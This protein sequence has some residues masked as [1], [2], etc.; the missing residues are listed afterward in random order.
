MKS[1]KKGIISLLAFVMALTLTPSVFAATDEDASGS[2]TAASYKVTNPGAS[3]EDGLYSNKTLSLNDDGTGTITLETY[4]TG[5]IQQTGTPTDIVLVLDVSQ[6][7]SQS[8]GSTTRLAA[9]KAAVSTFI[10]TTAKKNEAAKTE[11]LKSRISIVSFSG[12]ATVVSDFSTDATTLKSKV[13]SLTTSRG[14][15]ADYGMQ[16]AQSQVSSI[17]ASRESNKVVIFFTDGEPNHGSGSFDTSVAND[18]ISAAKTIKASGAT[19][20]SIG[21]VSG[22][23]P[24]LDPTQSSTSNINKFLHGISS[25]YPDATTYTNL[26]TRAKDSKGNDLTCYKSATNASELE[27]IFDDIGEEAVPSVKLDAS[28][29]VQDAMSEYVVS[30]V[31]DDNPIQLYTSKYTGNDT[32]ADPVAAPD[33]VTAD[34][35]DGIVKVTGFDFEPVIDKEDGTCQGQKLIVEIPVKLTDE[36]KSMSGETLNSNDEDSSAIYVEGEQTPVRKFGTPTVGIPKTKITVTANSAEKVYDGKALTD[37]GYTIEGTLAK[38]DVLTAVVEGTQ[39][40]A[41]SSPNEVKS[42]K[43]MRGD[44]DVTDMYD[45]TPKNGT[46]TVTPIEDKVTV[47]ITGKSGSYDYDDTKKTVTGYTASSSNILYNVDGDKKDYEFN[48]SDSVSGTNVDTYDMGLRAEDFKNTNNNFTNVEFVIEKDGQ[49]T[50]TPKEVTFEGETANKIY[51]GEEQTITGITADGLVQGHEYSG[52]TYAAKGTN[53]GDYNGKFSGTLVITDKEG[54]DVTKNYNVTKTPGTLTITPFTDEVVVT[55]KE[56]SGTYEYDGTEKKVT[57]YTVSINNAKYTEDDFTF[58]GDATV[59]RTDAGTSNME[60]KESD[61]DNKNDNFENVKFVIEDG[62]LKITKKEVT[63]TG[64]TA[65]KVY[66]RQE[67]EING[68][69]QSGLVDGHELTGL[70]YA[71]KGTE[72]GEYDGEFTGEEV[73]KDAKG[74]DVT[75]NYKVTKKPGK[76]TITSV[77]DEVIVTIRGNSATY[78]YDGTEKKATGYSVVSINNTNYT[79]DDFT[80]SGDATVTRTD[81]GTSNMELKESDFDNKN[82]NFE[83]VKFVIEDGQLKITKKAVTFKGETASKVYNRKEQKITKI[84]DTG[85]LDGHK[86]SGLEYVAKGTDVGEYDGEFSGDVLITDAEG[87]DV[88][89]NY[90]VTKNQGKLTITPVEEEIVV[91]ITEHSGKETYDGTEKKVTGYDASSSNDLYIV[92]GDSKDFEFTGDATVTGTDVD[93]YNMELKKSDFENKNKNFNK[94]TFVIVDGQLE[95][96]KKAVTFKGETASKVYTGEEQ[97]INGIT[98]DGLIEGHEYSELTYSAK[99]KTVGTTDGTFSGEATIKDAKGNDVTKNYDVTKTPGTL[100]I[101]EYTDEIIVT[102]TENSGTY[103]Y[104]GTEK[105]VT[106]YTVSINNDKYTEDDFTFSGDATVTRTDAGTSNM[107][108]K[109]S[110]FDNKNENFNKVTFVIVDGQLVITK[111]AVTF[112]GETASKVYNREEQEITGITDAG[113]VD[114][115][116]YSGLEYVAKGT[117]VGDYN[118]KF[119]GSLVITDKEGNNVTENYDVTKTPGTLTIT[120]ITEEVVVTIRENSA[121]Y[122]Y[123][124]TEKKATGYSVVSIDNPNYTKDDFTFSGDATVTRTDAGTS[125]MELKESDFDNKNDNFENVKFVI[126]DGQLKITKKAVTFEGE[127]TTREYN[128]EEQKITGITQNGLVDGHEYSELTYSAKGTNVGE[129]DG[130]FSGEVVIKDAKGNDVTKN[131]KVTTKPGKLTITPVQREI[132]VTITEHSGTETYDGTE[133]KVTG[134]DASSNDDIYYVEGDKKDFEFSGNATVTG[135]DVGTYDM[136]LKASD[137]ENTN[138]NFNKVTF[139]IKDGQ[140]IITPAK[141]T[142]YVEL[143]PKNTEKV[144]DGT[145]LA[146]GEAT[147]KDSLGKNRL[148]IEYSVDGKTWTEDYKEITATNVADSKT[149]KVRVSD[150]DKGNY[151]GY[152]E[153]TE[154]I[155]ITPATLKVVTPSAKKTYDGEPLTKKGTISGL[156][157]GETLTFKTTGTQTK[158]GKSDN[159]YEIV[160]DGTAVESNYTIVAEIGELEVTKAKDTP[161]TGDDSNVVLYGFMGLTALAAE[162][163]MVSRRRRN[164][165]K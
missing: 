57:G 110:D 157:E 113:L 22:A 20:Y 18:A 11:D 6:S 94:V 2:G 159:T 77:T 116:K 48:G 34:V 153:G 60:L 37:N 143:T 80:F 14:T 138:K 85:L 27:K 128:R 58:S 106:G 91:T 63:F 156:I 92:E 78:E 21:V 104:D 86:Y 88:T 74:N 163:F 126:E 13:N 145:P 51:N 24:S 39:T 130:E 68:I 35:S 84:T 62:Q 119:S 26:G 67:Q 150:D 97:E 49:L 65:S 95:I 135:T 137:F 132:V 82:D 9:L 45:I 158:V 155:T 25:N 93:T 102:I 55:I 146:A 134:Y 59:T 12:S 117:N 127:T 123:D 105:K 115:H 38:G 16:K 139:V 148:K 54:N 140:L 76:L 122:E 40:N 46:L 61:F 121:T 23:D 114:G 165:A 73:I 101:T 151:E 72:V 107:E 118:G 98:V 43:V 109:E 108:L 147:A 89:K 125:N 96:T 154:T 124:G 41:G 15:A 160:W 29:V 79:K 42:Y 162:L 164:G 8:M 103:E 81:A 53:V 47:T 32:F 52:L 4:V 3:S 142:N 36:A 56:N 87:N 69:T 83:N 152:V 141:I 161:D 75:K 111:K 99:R 50:I 90:K 136:E 71:A 144:Y 19:V 31:S 133:K 33:A 112:K 129:Y 64:E 131:Y 30:D 5:S 17:P 120:P 1:L 149:V 100:T 44:K 10:D 66:N 70:K 7:M 28:S